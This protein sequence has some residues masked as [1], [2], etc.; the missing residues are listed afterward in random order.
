MKHSH[1]YKVKNKNRYQT[2][3]KF[4][5]LMLTK[6]FSFLFTKNDMEKAKFRASR[7]LEDIPKINSNFLDSFSMFWYTIGI[8]MGGVIFSGLTYF[9][10]S[11]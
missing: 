7:N 11:L 1:I 3:N 4:Y 9:L 8:V 5:Y 2:A 6:Q 10:M